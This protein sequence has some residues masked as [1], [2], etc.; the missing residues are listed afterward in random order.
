MRLNVVCSE[1][2]TI[3]W[4]DSLITI[5]WHHVMWIVPILWFQLHTE[6]ENYHAVLADMC[7]IFFN[8]VD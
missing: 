4:Y 7:H 8:K 1:T 3:L 2:P 6:L 5:W